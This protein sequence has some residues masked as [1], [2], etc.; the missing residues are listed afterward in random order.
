MDKNTTGDGMLSAI[1]LLNVLKKSGKRLSAL[2]DEIPIYPQTLLNVI[3]DNDKKTAALADEEMH[4]KIREVEAIL[5]EKGR[6]L[7][8]ASGTEPLIRIM[9][10]G[11][12]ENEIEQFALAIAEPL[13]KNAGGRIK[14][15]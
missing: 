10:E 8:R 14:G 9:L 11:Q 12:D 13:L 15:R 4:A 7:V 1:Q 2:A 3:V 6:V 5:G